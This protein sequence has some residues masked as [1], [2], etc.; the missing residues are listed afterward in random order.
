M[1]EILNPRYKAFTEYE[2]KIMVKMF[3]D[4]C[5]M[6]EIA[7]ALPN[8]TE[9]SVASKLFKMGKKRRR[10]ISKEEWKEI[11]RKRLEKTRQNIEAMKKHKN[12][13]CLSDD[14]T[15]EWSKKLIMTGAR[16]KMINGTKAFF[17]GDSPTTI[18]EISFIYDSI[19]QSQGLGDREK[20]S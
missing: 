9:K 7:S 4:N 3:E 1:E 13:F 2:I 14:I 15:D 12:H 20:G 11:V 10:K 17:I 18:K 19:K 16:I 6:K 8:R 5:S